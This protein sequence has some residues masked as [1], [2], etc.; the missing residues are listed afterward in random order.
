MGIFILPWSIEADNLFF[1]PKSVGMDKS[2]T[3]ILF[4]KNGGFYGGGDPSL[5]IVTERGIWIARAGQ[6]LQPGWQGQ[7]L[8]GLG[9]IRGCRSM[10]CASVGRAVKVVVARM[11]GCGT[12]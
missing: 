12:G 1:C 2:K 7:P 4:V 3:A 8:N 11:E 6:V 10:P 9:R 5:S